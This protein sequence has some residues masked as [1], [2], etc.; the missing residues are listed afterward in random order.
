MKSSARRSFVAPYPFLRG[1][2]RYLQDR[3][4]SYR[5]M[6]VIYRELFVRELRRLDIED[7]FFP[8]GAAANHGLLYLVLRCYVELPVRRVLDVGAGQTSLLLDALNRKLGKAEI[9]TLEHDPAWAERVAAQVSHQ[10]MRRDLIK[11][12]VGGHATQMH[13]TTGLDGPFQFII[14]DAP[15]GVPRYSRLGLLHLMQTRMD[16]KDFAAILDDADRPA[17][18]QTM[19]VCRRWLKA[20]GLQFRQAQLRAAKRQ[21]LCAGGALQ[22]AA[23]F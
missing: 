9:I 20:E 5:S 11:S 21:W 13:D 4:G 17:E 18:R 8:V 16:H 14:M 19:E 2:I 10:V 7:R 23:F 12:Q 15:P 3:Y 22:S 6:E 1:A